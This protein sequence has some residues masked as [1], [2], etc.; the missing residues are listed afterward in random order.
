[1]HFDLS[2]VGPSLVRRLEPMYRERGAHL[3]DAPV[4]SSP[5]NVLTR[6]VMVLVGGDKEVYEQHKPLLDSFADFVMHCGGIGTGQICK[7]INNTTRVR[8]GAGYNRGADHGYEGRG[9]VGRALASRQPG[10][11][12]RQGLLAWPRC[13]SKAISKPP[14][15]TLAL[16]RK[17]V[18]LATEVGRDVGVPMPVAKH[19]RANHDSG[20]EQAWDGRRRT[21]ASTF[22]YRRRWQT[23]KCA[24]MSRP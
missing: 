19:R 15:F 24:R 20:H 21:T 16:S 13:C 9:R 4:M 14:T 11:L 7:V 17:D 23:R 22:S 8:R 3:L 18:G 5:T 2:T 6:N 10:S 1:M 12:G